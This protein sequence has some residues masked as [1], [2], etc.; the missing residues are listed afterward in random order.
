MLIYPNND[1]GS[2]VILNE[3]KKIKDNKNIKQIRSMRFEYYLT[4][5]KNAR[6]IIGNSSSGVR[7]SQNYGVPC[8]NLGKRQFKRSN[9]KNIHNSKDLF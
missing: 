9:T 2:E 1:Y 7:E 3:I 8:I 4:L 5:L 6:F